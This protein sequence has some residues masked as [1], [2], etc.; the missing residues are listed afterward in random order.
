[1][2][3]SD[4]CFALFPFSCLF[5]SCSYLMIVS[6]FYSFFVAPP[7]LSREHD[8]RKGEKGNGKWNGNYFA[9]FFFLLF[10]AIF[11]I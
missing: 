8:A 4:V 6:V 3:I 10:F 5:F 7:S 1:V 2:L 11:G 9:F